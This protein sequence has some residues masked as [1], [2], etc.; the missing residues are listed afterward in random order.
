MIS[1][2]QWYGAWLAT[3]MNNGKVEEQIFD[4]EAKGILWI[5]LAALLAVACTDGGPPNLSRAETLTAACS[6]ICLRDALCDSPQY[7]AAFGD[8]GCEAE[9]VASVQTAPADAGVTQAQAEACLFQIATSPCG[10]AYDACGG[11]P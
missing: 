8:A 6:A 1:L 5:A 4:S 7:S 3:R 9:C 10:K 2:R 11:L